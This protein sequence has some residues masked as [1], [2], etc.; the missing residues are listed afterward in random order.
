MDGEDTS[1]TSLGEVVGNDL[2]RG[3]GKNVASPEFSMM[4]IVRKSLNM[5]CSVKLF[6]RDLCHIIHG[7]KEQ[8]AS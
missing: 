7:L 4:R 1:V 6:F 5:Q 8:T 3:L 2:L